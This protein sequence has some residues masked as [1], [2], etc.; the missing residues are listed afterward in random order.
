MGFA[1]HREGSR[2]QAWGSLVERATL[3]LERAMGEKNDN[4]V[5]TLVTQAESLLAQVL[6]DMNSSGV[7]SP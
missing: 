6:G 7:G 5:R 3:D 2:G 1:G 4:A